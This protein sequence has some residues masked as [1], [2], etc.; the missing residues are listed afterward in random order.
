MPTNET[1]LKK[2]A[3]MTGGVY[4]PRPEAAFEP[5]GRLA[6]RAEPLWPYLLAAAACL[7]VFDVAL[8]R[9]DWSL[10]RGGRS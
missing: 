8:R 6:T 1:L 5:D 3:E 4:N 9:I 7:L 2:V 10:L